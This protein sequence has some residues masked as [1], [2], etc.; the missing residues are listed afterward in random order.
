M[1]GLVLFLALLWVSPA[2]A[3]SVASK[4]NAAKYKAAGVYAQAILGC[5]A[6]AIQKGDTTEFECIAK[7]ADKLEKAFVRAE[8]KGDCNGSDGAASAQG[9]ADT[10]SER[11]Q[12]DPARADLLHEVR[13]RQ[14]A[15]LVLRERSRVHRRRRYGCRAG[16][17]LRR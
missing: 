4:C 3:I 5:Q 8:K 7:A 17:G 15:V 14:H 16:R 10:V 6:K 9:Y 2:S 1:R 13:R 11:P 12:G